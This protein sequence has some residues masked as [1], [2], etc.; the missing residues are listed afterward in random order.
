MRRVYFGG[1]VV[2]MTDLDTGDGRSIQ[3]VRL[4]SM[5][6]ALIRVGYEGTTVLGR[7]QRWSR[8]TRTP[9]APAGSALS[10]VTDDFTASS[11]RKRKTRKKLIFGSLRRIFYIHHILYIH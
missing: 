1:G 8:V 10:V 6:W 9:Q 2:S 11:N 5:L 3:E 7:P 4:S